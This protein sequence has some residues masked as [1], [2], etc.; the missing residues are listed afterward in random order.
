VVSG[1]TESTQKYDVIGDVHGCIN[2]L[3]Q[4]LER[5]GY[6]DGVH[7]ERRRSS[8]SATSSTGAPTPPAC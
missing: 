3:T 7:P 1:Q 2:E 4:L 6:V 5:L 8:S